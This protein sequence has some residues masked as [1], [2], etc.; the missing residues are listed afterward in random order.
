[1][2]GPD[3]DG[4]YR[5]TMEG[6]D[7]YD[8][9]TN[10]ISDTKDSKVAAWFLDSDYDGRTFCITQAFFPD[11]SAWE[12]LANALGQK[13]VVPAALALWAPNVIFAL[14]GAVLFVLAARERP[15]GI[16]ARLGNG[17]AALR[18]RWQPASR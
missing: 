10:S 12:K 9:V 4:C 2:K 8:P 5:V 17:L 14:F 11:S 18:M 16:P 1:M 15:L 13:G 6:M 3:D 7:I